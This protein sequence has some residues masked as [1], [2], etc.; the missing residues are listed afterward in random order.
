MAP[1]SIG[2]CL[3]HPNFSVADLDYISLLLPHFS[4][5]TV[6]AS[7]PASVL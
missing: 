7:T 4:T 2:N 3:R 1:L 6:P 5:L